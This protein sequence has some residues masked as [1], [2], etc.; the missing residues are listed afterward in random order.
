MHGTNMIKK[1]GGDLIFSAVTEGS[2]A[3]HTVN[4]GF[5][6]AIHFTFLKDVGTFCWGCI[7]CNGRHYVFT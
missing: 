7:C 4:L 5:S 6:S 3:Q 2:L 1:K